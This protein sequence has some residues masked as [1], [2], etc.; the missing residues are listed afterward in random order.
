[1][2]NEIKLK[3]ISTSK[4]HSRLSKSFKVLRTYMFYQVIS[5]LGQMST[6]TKV[7][8]IFK[9]CM[10]LKQHKG[11]I[12]EMKLNISEEKVNTYAY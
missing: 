4:F 5:F 6:C 8:S 12:I 11:P 9:E 7:T 1:L 2:T 10:V 3:D